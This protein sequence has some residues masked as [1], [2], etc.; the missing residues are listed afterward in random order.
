MIDGIIIND[1]NVLADLN[2]ERVEKVEVVKTPCLTGD[3]ILHG[4]VNVITK[5]GDFSDI[6]MP[7]YAVMIPYKVV[8]EV[9]DFI[10]PDYSD[11]KVMISRTPDLRN[12]L[13]WNP[14]LKTDSSGKANLTFHTSDLPGNYIIYIHG[15]SDSGK[16]V[17]VR[18]SFRVR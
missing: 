15:I 14:L 1:L 6:S 11:P 8:E 5:T 17:V 3:R 9:P 12:T 4:I 10:A 16:I 7:E 18:K 13:Y 2:P